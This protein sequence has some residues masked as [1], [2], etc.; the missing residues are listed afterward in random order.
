[1]TTIPTVFVT[2]SWFKRLVGLSDEEAQSGD[3]S[4]VVADRI[5]FDGSLE[6]AEVIGRSPQSYIAAGESVSSFVG[7]QITSKLAEYGLEEIEPDEWYPLEIPLAMLYDMRDE[8]GGVRMRNMGQNVPEH[9]EFPPELSEVD[10]A[11]ASID[12]AYHQNHR[13]SEIGS[14]EFETEGPNE[15]VMIC[16]NPYPCEFDKGLI[17]GVAKKFANNPVTVEEVG[18]QCRS[19]GDQHCEYHVEWI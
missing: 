2:T 3:G 17:K 15:G 9:V 18:D 19:D 11:L 5:G 8:Y 7:K 10:E 1:M 14:Y 12:A 4:P 6:D 16:E 13:G